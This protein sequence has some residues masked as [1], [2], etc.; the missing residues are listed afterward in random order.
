VKM[1][2]LFLCAVLLVTDAAVANAGMKHDDFILTPI[3][4]AGTHLLMRCIHLMTNKSVTGL[5]GR[6]PEESLD[7]AKQENK[8]LKYHHFNRNLAKIMQERGYKN[9]FLCRDPRD[10]CIS[11]IFYL[12]RWKG[13]QKTKRDVFVVPEN[14]D[15][16]SFDDKLHELI[17][18][19]SRQSYIKTWYK[20]LVQWSMKPDTLIVK[21]EDLVGGKGGGSDEAQ[22]Q[23]LTNIAN[24]IHLDIDSARIEAIAQMLYKPTS[25][26]EMYKGVTYVPGQVGN[27]KRYFNEEHKRIFK[28]M[29]NPLLIRFGYEKNWNW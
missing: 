18:G 27:W 19:K 29:Y 23:T 10:A 3:P 11:L 22:R 5:Q 6:A 14:W 13:T 9:I 28:M 21:F 1:P 15:Q 4:K 8:I 12:D 2:L 16:L 17:A 26:P 7:F 20:P 24:F 25:K